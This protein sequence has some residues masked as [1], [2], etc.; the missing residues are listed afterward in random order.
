[1]ATRLRQLKEADR[2]G[3]PTVSAFRKASGTGFFLYN[4]MWID[5]KF[6]ADADLTTIQFGSEAYFKLIEKAPHLVDAFKLGTKIV[7]LTAE[8][9]VVA[10]CARRRREDV[11]CPGRRGFRRQEEEVIRP[12]KN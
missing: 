10:V 3:N 5:E 11:G 4:D 7:V 1:M 2:A 6:D 9:N 8:G 12:P